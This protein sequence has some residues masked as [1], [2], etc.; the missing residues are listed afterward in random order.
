MSE[1]VSYHSAEKA[2][3]INGPLQAEDS[4]VAIHE[5]ALG[6]VGIHEA[7]KALRLSFGEGWHK[8]SLTDDDGRRRKL[9]KFI[10]RGASV[11][12]D[13]IMRIVEGASEIEKQEIHGVA[14][15]T[16]AFV[17]ELRKLLGGTELGAEIDNPHDSQLMRLLQIRFP[18]AS[19]YELFSK[20]HG[21]LIATPNPDSLIV[22]S[23]ERGHLAQKIGSLIEEPIILIHSQSTGRRDKVLRYDI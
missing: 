18:E 9:G 7:A 14:E 16:A 19:L 20:A 11:P 15:M 22:A 5:P 3:V 10:L 23:E 8:E 2:I 12:E 21:P 1:V 17:P 4:L 13:E 6:G